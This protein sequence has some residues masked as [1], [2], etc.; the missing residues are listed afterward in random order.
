VKRVLQIDG[1]GIR[2]IIPGVV[3]KE[4]EKRT[5]KKIYELFDLICGTSTGSILGGA[6]AAGANAE[7]ILDIYVNE[8]KKLFKKN[9]TFPFRPKYDREKFRRRIREIVGDITLKE[10]KTDFMATTYNLCSGRTHF[11]KSY[12]EKDENVK[13]LDLMSWS[14]LSAAVYFGKINDP[15][16][17]YQYYYNSGAKTEEKGGVLQDGGQGIQNCTLSFAINEAVSR[18]WFEEKTFVLSLGCG[19]GE[20][21]ES[22]EKCSKSKMLGQVTDYVFTQGR[23]EATIDQVLIAKYLAAKRP[24]VYVHRLDASLNKKLNKLDAVKYIND[25][26]SIGESLKHR[27]DKFEELLK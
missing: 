1:G 17:K 6:L 25:F 14:G 10:L 5:G 8:G 22:Y 2:G 20:R 12:A 21:K 24:K 15:N 27:I 19:S 7:M 4:I 3:C 16:F 26:V 9:F 18:K 13:L 23:E 11:I